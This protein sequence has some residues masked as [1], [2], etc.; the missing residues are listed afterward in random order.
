MGGKSSKFKV[1]A[2]EILIFILR[3]LARL[4]LWRYK[5]IIVGVTGSVGKSSA[6]EAIFSVLK[7]KFSV[8]RNYKNYNNEIGV[9]LTIIGAEGGKSS[10]LKWLLVFIRGLAGI[11]FT[12]NY[13]KILVLEMGADKIGDI[14]YLISFVPCQVGV[15]TTIGEIPVHVEFFQTPEQVVKEKAKLISC[16]SPTGWAVLNF[17]DERVKKISQQ[18][19]AKTI[20]YGFS[21]EADLRASNLEISLEDLTNAHLSFKIEYQGSIM[22]FRLENILGKHQIYSVLAAVAVGLVFGMNL[23]EISQALKEYSSP[24]GR[25]RLIA[26][27]KNSWLIDDTY[28]SSPSA[29]LAALE[30]LSQIKN[31]R[32]IA[33]LGDMLELGAYAEEAHRRVATSAAQ[34]A[35]LFLA[36]GERAIFMADQAK[37]EGMDER[38][39]FYFA[40]SEDAGKKLQDLIEEGDIILVKGSQGVR[41]EKIVKEIMAE[42][43]KAKELLVRQEKEW[44]KK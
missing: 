29:T 8:R 34:K 5:P 33:V 13:P 19:R 18:S 7:K 1:M 39:V 38:K 21:E 32:K 3:I 17:D 43:Q 4:T 40:S 42:P 11:I 27:I 26:G 16:L 6:K 31:G 28:N 12:K 15:I 36:V 2:K 22:P 41:M 10:P 14:S 30:T 9:P 20:T 25:M 37:K 24:A 23:V 35:D 44:Q